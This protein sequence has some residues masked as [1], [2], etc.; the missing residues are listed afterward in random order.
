MIH[1]VA[2][3]IVRGT[4]FRNRWAVRSLGV[5]EGPKH[6]AGLEPRTGMPDWQHSGSRALRPACCLRGG[7]LAAPVLYIAVRRAAALELAGFIVV[8]TCM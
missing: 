1:C 5:S 7:E 2:R 4:G 3:M 8:I 6:R